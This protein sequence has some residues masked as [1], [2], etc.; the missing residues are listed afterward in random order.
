MSVELFQKV[1]GSEITNVEFYGTTNSGF[2]CMI[3][4]PDG[5]I[6]QACSELDSFDA[7]SKAYKLRE[8]DKKWIS[9]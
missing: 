6:Y 8:V 3:F 2:S 9:L 7:F 1:M 5:K 4:E